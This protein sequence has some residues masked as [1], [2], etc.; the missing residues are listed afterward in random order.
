VVFL[1]WHVLYLLNMLCPPYTEQAIAKPSHTQTSSF[2]VNYLEHLG[3]LCEYITR[4]GSL[5]NVTVSL[6][7]E[8]LVKL[9]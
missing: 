9:R 3:R 2:Y 6:G 5:I 7:C 8:L 4:F 1:H